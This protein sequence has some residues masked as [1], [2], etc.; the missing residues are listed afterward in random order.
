MPAFTASIAAASAFSVYKGI[1][2]VRN[3]LDF[4]FDGRTARIGCVVVF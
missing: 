3:K 1:D 2:Q 4:K